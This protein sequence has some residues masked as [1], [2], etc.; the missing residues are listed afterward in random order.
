MPAPSEDKWIKEATSP[1][2]HNPT[3]VASYKEEGERA[4]DLEVSPHSTILSLA[5]FVALSFLCPINRLDLE[6]VMPS[7]IEE[8]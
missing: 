5:K 6:Y 1:A 7:P 3:H 2:T 4:E 8:G